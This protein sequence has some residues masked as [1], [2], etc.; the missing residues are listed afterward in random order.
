MLDQ[1]REATSNITE[2]AHFNYILTNGTY[3][4]AHSH[5]RLDLLIS[6]IS[7]DSHAPQ[8]CIIASQ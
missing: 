2:N 8:T 4:F 3:L 5:R 6:P 1:L 7:H